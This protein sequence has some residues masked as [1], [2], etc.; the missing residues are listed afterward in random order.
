MTILA[1]TTHA[2]GEL[3]DIG[4]VVGLAALLFGAGQDT[5][6]RLIA[7]MLKVLAE[8]DDLQA[9]VRAAPN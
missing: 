7:A 4:E 1:Q 5:T 9:Q 3:P 6:V 2:D 8:D